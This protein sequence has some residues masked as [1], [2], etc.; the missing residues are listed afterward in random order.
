[1]WFSTCHFF[2]VTRHHK[3]YPITAVLV[4][5]AVG[6]QSPGSAG[7]GPMGQLGAWAAE[8]SNSARRESISI[9][10]FTR[11][12]PEALAPLKHHRLPLS[13]R[14]RLSLVNALAW[15]ISSPSPP[16]SCT[17]SSVWGSAAWAFGVHISALRAQ[18]IYIGNHHLVE[19]AVSISPPSIRL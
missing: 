15:S 17:A 7:D 8:S 2:Q 10:D 9:L 3:K 14:S 12:L 1:M 16:S 6:C 5:N 11:I 13:T 4:Y 18:H 19:T